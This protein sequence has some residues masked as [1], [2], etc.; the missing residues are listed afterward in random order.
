[1]SRSQNEILLAL[2]Q[3]KAIPFSES[4]SIQLIQPA[5]LADII[6]ML[7]DDRVNQYLFFAPAPDELYQGFFG[8]IIE[9]TEQAIKDQ[10]WPDNPTFIIR[11]QQG[12]YMG[13]TAI[14]AVMFME[15]NFELGYQLPFHAWGQGIATKACQLM[16]E[17][18]FT[19]LD[20]HKISADCYGTNIGSYKTLEKCHFV[21]EG[22]QKDYFK[23]DAGFDDK[24]YYGIT[25]KEFNALKNAF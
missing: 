11:N 24:L 8:P 1:M 20:A 15:G 4:L 6:T 18:G 22:C 7:A 19:Q 2:K 21:Q 3:G 5:D 25:E 14:T 10:C 13:M 17:L 23:T 12:K 16:T 9:N